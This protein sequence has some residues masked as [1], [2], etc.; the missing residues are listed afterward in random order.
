MQD[1]VGGIVD[2]G[3]VGRDEQG[4]AG[5]LDDVAEE[6]RDF[7][8]RLRIEVAG[9]FVGDDDAWAM[10]KGASQSHTLLLAA[11]KFQPPMVGAVNQPNQS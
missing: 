11:G 9:G 4:N 1:A 10:D 6:L 5:L 2:G 7:A 8:R 3:V